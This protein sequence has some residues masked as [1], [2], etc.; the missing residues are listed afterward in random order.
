MSRVDELRKNIIARWF[1]VIELAYLTYVI[2]I[3]LDGHRYTTRKMCSC[4]RFFAPA[5]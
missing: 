1:G 3:S 5:P 2:M 4:D